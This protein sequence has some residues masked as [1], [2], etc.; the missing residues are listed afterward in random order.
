MSDHICTHPLRKARRERAALRR[1]SD[2]LAWKA[3]MHPNPD[4][5]NLVGNDA[6]CE[7]KAAIADKDLKNL[8]KKGIKA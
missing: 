2:S 6:A 4:F 5:T 1:K 7:H 3:G 8:E